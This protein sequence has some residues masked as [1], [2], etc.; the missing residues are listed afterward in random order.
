VYT[1][2][3]LL[4]RWAVLA[5]AVAVTDWLMASFDIQGGLVSILIVAAVLGL[6]NALIRP[7]VMAL[8]CP[9]VILTLG[10][11]A[12]VVNALMLSLTAW[13]LPSLINLDNFWATLIA[14][15]II[16]LVSAALMIFVHDESKW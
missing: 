4:A 15:L 9:L 2:R 8:T 16:S 3:Y 1:M 11:F 13:L 14:S 10:L 7:I 12:L 5:L 6:V